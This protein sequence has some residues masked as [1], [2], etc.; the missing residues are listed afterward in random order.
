MTSANFSGRN[1]LLQWINSTL[2]LHLT[3][4]EQV[5]GIAARCP[6]PAPPPPPVLA[7]AIRTRSPTIDTTSLR[8]PRMAPWHANSWTRCTLGRSPC[9][10]HASP[11]SWLKPIP[12]VQTLPRCHARVVPRLKHRG[13]DSGPACNKP[14]TC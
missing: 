4:I 13:P 3:K 11:V 6:A 8:R 14:S 9:T 7:P 1:E 5:D 12:V 10:R 2:G